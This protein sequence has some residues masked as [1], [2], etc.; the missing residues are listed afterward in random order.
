MG[1]PVGYE[2]WV[3]RSA[4][5]TVPYRCTACGFTDT[6]LVAGMGSGVGG[7]RGYGRD[8]ASGL[9]NVAASDEINQDARRIAADITCPKCGAGGRRAQTLQHSVV[10]KVRNQNRVLFLVL[11]LFGAPMLLAGW[12]GFALAIVLTVGA[13]VWTRRRE[14]AALD[15]RAAFVDAALA[16]AALWSVA[17]ERFEQRQS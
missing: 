5:I 6:A 1:I 3:T 11:F 14:A 13:V 2:A 9:A 7:G 17:P 12:G 16:D 8:A 4:K 10:Q 15:G